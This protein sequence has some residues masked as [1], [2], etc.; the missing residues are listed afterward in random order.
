[1][2]NKIDLRDQNIDNNQLRIIA[3]RISSANDIKLLNY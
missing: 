3:N 1:M 2:S